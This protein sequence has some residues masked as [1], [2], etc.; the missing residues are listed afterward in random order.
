MKIAGDVPFANL[1]WTVDPLRLWDLGG[2]QLPRP[3]GCLEIRV[4]ALGGPRK[5]RQLRKNSENSL[6]PEMS[7]RVPIGGKLSILDV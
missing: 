5:A 7:G 6:Q 3:L 4:Q 1:K 2:L